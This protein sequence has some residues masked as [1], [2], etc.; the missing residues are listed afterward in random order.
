MSH[1]GQGDSN[2]DRLKT[3]NRRHSTAQRKIDPPG[4]ERP[5][6]A[7]KAMSPVGWAVPTVMD[8]RA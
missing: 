1:D 3:L 5:D 6:I 4:K 7:Q 8:G 2:G